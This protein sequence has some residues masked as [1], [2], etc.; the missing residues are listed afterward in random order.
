MVVGDGGGGCFNAVF[1]TVVGVFKTGGG[2]LS[3]DSS[4]DEV[5]DAPLEIV[6]VVGA[7]AT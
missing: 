7:L 6:C 4:S 5:S 1:N 3:G 2:A